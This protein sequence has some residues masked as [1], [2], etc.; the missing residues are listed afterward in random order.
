MI[1]GLILSIRAVVD[2]SHFEMDS[3][4]L[5]T[6]KYIM[7]MIVC[8]FPEMPKTFWE[9][10]EFLETICQYEILYISNW[11]YY[12]LSQTIYHSS[13][14]RPTFSL[15]EIYSEVIFYSFFF[16]YSAN[17]SLLC[18]LVSNRDIPMVTLNQSKIL[19]EIAN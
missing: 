15:F 19:I 18:L 10:T 5:V 8:I 13:Q 17:L 6:T 1:W 9:R 2:A 12:H 14:I 3:Q 7:L 16:E 4:L 11:P